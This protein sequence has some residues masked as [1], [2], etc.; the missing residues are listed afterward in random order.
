MFY[1][2]DV[3]CAISWVVRRI[4]PNTCSDCTC[5]RVLSIDRT[6]LVFRLADSD[7][8]SCPLFCGHCTVLG[9]GGLMGSQMGTPTVGRLYC[10]IPL[11]VKG[12]NLHRLEEIFIYLFFTI[13]WAGYFSHD[14]S[15]VCCIT[16]HLP[17]NFTNS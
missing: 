17:D 14:L 9:Y 10:T 2:V 11:F 13:Y 15:N 5:L 16:H 12:T 3:T 4:T 7:V 1:V 6:P 8:H